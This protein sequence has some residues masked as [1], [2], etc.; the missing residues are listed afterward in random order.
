MA[1][2]RASNSHTQRERAHRK[3]YWNIS[4]DAQ[5]DVTLTKKVRKTTN[6]HTI[7]TAQNTSA[8]ITEECHYMSCHHTLAERND[9]CPVM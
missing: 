1:I 8:I 2:R 4:S 5:M 7:Q 3:G 9:E 6:T